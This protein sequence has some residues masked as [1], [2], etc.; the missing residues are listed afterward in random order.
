MGPFGAFV[1]LFVYALLVCLPCGDGKRRDRGATV[2]K[3]HGEEG[4]SPRVKEYKSQQEK[5]KSGR[6]EE[7]DKGD[8]RTRDIC[9]YWCDRMERRSEEGRGKRY[10]LDLWNKVLARSLLEVVLQLNT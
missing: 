4:N 3:F 10:D 5:G 9:I 6:A 8:E 1:C 7:K 2:Q